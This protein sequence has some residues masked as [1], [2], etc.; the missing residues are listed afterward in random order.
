[1]EVVKGRFL[2]RLNR[3]VV[4]CM[5]GGKREFA[6]LPNPGR[7]LEILLPD[8]PVYLLP[9]RNKSRYRF[10]V[11]GAEKSGK[12]VMLHT[13]H[14][15]RVVEWL[16]GEGLIPELR[17]YRIQRK[18]VACGRSRFDF[19]LSDYQ[20]ELLLEVK[21]C[22]LFHRGIAMFPDAPTERGK[23]HI[24]HLAESGRGAVLFVIHDPD[25]RV[26]VPDYHTDPEFASTLYSLRKEIKILAVSLGWTEE[27]ELKGQV[28]P[29][30][31]G[32]ELIGKELVDSGYYAVVLELESE[33][34]IEI[35]S[36]GRINFPM[37][38]Y[39]YIGSA[40]GMLTK[41]IN[42][43]LLSRKRMH[44]H[45]DYLRRYAR[46]THTFP[47]RASVSRECELANAISRVSDWQISGFGSSDCG[48]N[49]HLFGFKEA[50]VHNRAFINSIMDFRVMEILKKS[51]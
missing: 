8:T 50:P 45:I 35:G 27:L 47:I 17:N 13:H 3:F 33:R 2:E 21:S 28:R 29:V 18:E 19:L 40:R 30:N 9:Q 24:M 49:S 25:A 20:G 46:L 41:R 31:I 42:R 7:L 36:L 10:V 23:R 34:V 11:Y 16:I 1:L 22:T 48:C 12:V 5:V 26:F 32:L 51:G 14:T 6:Y 44:W 43:H 37:G 15:N 38:H 39:V 4:S